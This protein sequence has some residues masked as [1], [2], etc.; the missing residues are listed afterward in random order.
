MKTCLEC[1]RQM[2]DNAQ[3][4]PHCGCPAPNASS[5]VYMDEE[6]L[7]Q[8]KSTDA[9]AI[10]SGIA[11]SVLFWAKILSWSVLIL[12]PLYGIIM[13]SIQGGYSW[14]GLPVFII[15]PIFLFF[16]IGECK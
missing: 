7:H 2:D 4:C 1:G 6:V 10:V 16:I 14:E 9:E 3:V 13:C 15:Y 11:E 8:G 12:G 5:R